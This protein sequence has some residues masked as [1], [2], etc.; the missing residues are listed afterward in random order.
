MRAGELDQSWLRPSRGRALKV[1]VRTD[2]EPR[3]S[4]NLLP[5]DAAID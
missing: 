5:V 4:M 1:G 2:R 3:D